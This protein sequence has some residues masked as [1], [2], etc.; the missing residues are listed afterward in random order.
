MQAYSGATMELIGLT[1][2][3]VNF[4]QVHC[5]AYLLRSQLR[6]SRALQSRYAGILFLAD[7]RARCSS[8]A[9]FSTEHKGSHTTKQQHSIQLLFKIKHFV[10]TPAQESKKETNTGSSTNPWVRITLCC[11]VYNTYL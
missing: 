8:P 11:C 1:L 7:A 4:H 3:C 9:E 2:L 5:A 6:Q 10:L